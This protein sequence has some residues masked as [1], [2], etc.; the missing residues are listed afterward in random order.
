LACFALIFPGTSCI[1]AA[2]QGFLEGHLKII[3]PRE[4]ELADETPSNITTENYADYPL[5]ILSSDGKKEIARLRADENGNYRVALPPG[6]YVLDVEGRPP[7]GHVRAKPQP[8]TVVSNQTVH[9][10]MNIDTGVR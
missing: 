9:V 2:P 4:V 10:D 1:T 5:I 3:S 8:F 6:D 7:K